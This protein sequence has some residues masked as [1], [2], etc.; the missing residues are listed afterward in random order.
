MLSFKELKA[1]TE[2]SAL[3]DLGA[4]PLA[5]LGGVSSNTRNIVVT[6]RPRTWKGRPLRIYKRKEHVGPFAHRIIH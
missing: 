3:S 6:R 4:G 5:A 2:D 1:V